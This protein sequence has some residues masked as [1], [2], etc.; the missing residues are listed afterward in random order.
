M[1][2]VDPWSTGSFIAMLLGVLLVAGGLYAR[3]GGKLRQREGAALLA[4]FAALIGVAVLGVG[5]YALLRA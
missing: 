2:G 4:G 1:A 3:R 5:L